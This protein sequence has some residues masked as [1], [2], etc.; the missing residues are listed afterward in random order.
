MSDLPL[1]H[2]RDEDALLRRVPDQPS[3]IS[4]QAGTVRPT[5]G[6]F[7]P[8][9]VDGGLSVDIRRLL[10]DPRAPELVLGNRPED[11]LVE[12]LARVPR[13]AGLD[14]EHAPLATNAA[15]ANVLGW[16]RF[17]RT[18]RK[19]IQRELALATAW[20]RQPPARDLL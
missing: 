3:M 15:H 16:D 7:Q 20:V 1:E 9:R 17:S 8:A 2:I 10:A 12:L 19:R 4:R 6:A 11:G 18:A 13:G 14:V 5:S